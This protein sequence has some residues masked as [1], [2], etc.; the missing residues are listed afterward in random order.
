M[1]QECAVLENSEL[2]LL[3]PRTIG[4]RVS[5]LR[6]RKGENLFAELPE[7]TTNRPDG[8]PYHFYGGHRLWLTPEDPIYSYGLDDR[9]VEIK[10]TENGLLVKKSMEPETG[11]EKSLLFALDA[12]RPRLTITHRLVNRGAASIEYSAW[13]ITQLKTGGVAILPQTLT[14][15]ELLPNRLLGLWPY[16]DLA[17]PCLTLGKSFILLRAEMKTPFKIGFPNPRG[18]LAYWLNGVLFVKRA[19]FEAHARYS[20]FGCSSECYCNQQFIELETLAPLAQFDPGTTITH[21]ETWDLYPDVP[22]PADE[23]A[24]W[25]IIERLGIE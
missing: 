2:E 7:F 25:K 17:S 3:I 20:D 24:V 5:S 19:V 9:E 16:T 11:I 8:K 10:E 13:A 15:T 6:F 22:S 23:A 12:D 14:P 1:D 18:W 21:T 4:P